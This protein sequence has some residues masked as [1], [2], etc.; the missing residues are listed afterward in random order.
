MSQVPKCQ[1]MMWGNAS[2]TVS[3]HSS[4]DL[5]TEWANSLPGS[6]ASLFPGS[7]CRTQHQVLQFSEPLQP[8]PALICTG[9]ADHTDELPGH[10]TGGCLHTPHHGISHRGQLCS[11]S[12]HWVLAA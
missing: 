1:D 8:L 12:Q 4:P 2:L 7:L 10:G 11:L 6:T 5:H 3:H 9:I